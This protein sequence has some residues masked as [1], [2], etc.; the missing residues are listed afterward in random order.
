MV[1][2]LVAASN[3]SGQFRF[4]TMNP[5]LPTGQIGL[6]VAGKLQLQAITEA[7]ELQPTNR[8]ALVWAPCHCVFSQFTSLKRLTDR[9]KERR[10]NLFG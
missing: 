4:D 9:R 8:P 2:L 1:E 10:E 6:A 5:K 7:I 3:V